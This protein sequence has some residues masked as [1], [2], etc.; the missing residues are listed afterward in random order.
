[1]ITVRMADYEAWTAEQ[2]PAWTTPFTR[3]VRDGEGLRPAPDPPESGDV[4]AVCLYTRGGTPTNA[5]LA[6]VREYGPH[7]RAAYQA[8]PERTERLA[9]AR[10]TI[11]A[12]GLTGLRALSV[13]EWDDLSDEERATAG[14]DARSWLIAAHLAGLMA[15]GG[16]D[17]R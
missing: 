4:L 3:P 13:P 14:V 8:S 6:A 11:A 2:G 16:D 5:D 17:S 15:D 7:L 1:M 10:Q 12:R 9:R